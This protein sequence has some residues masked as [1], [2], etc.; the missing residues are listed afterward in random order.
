LQQLCI[1]NAE[2]RLTVFGNINSIAEATG[3]NRGTSRRKVNRLL[4]SGLI[5]RA[6]DGSITISAQA[7]RS[8]ESQWP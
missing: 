7:F 1:F 2:R 5:E 6:V 8:A 4:A 3:M